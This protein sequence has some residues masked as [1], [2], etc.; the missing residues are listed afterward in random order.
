MARCSPSLQW[1]AELPELWA[2]RLILGHVN[3]PPYPASFGKMIPTRSTT[4]ESARVRRCYQFPLLAHRRSPTGLPN[5][6]T[7]WKASALHWI[8][9][10]VPL[11]RGLV[12]V[13]LEP[14]SANA[15]ILNQ[16][17]GLPKTKSLRNFTIASRVASV[18]I[19]WWFIRSTT[20]ST[21]SS[22]AVFRSSPSTPSYD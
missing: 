14:S 13:G 1:L 9:F 21:P 20:L 2:C 10:D 7:T 15:L 11:A 3:P 16:F 22:W 19:S 6:M 5:F 8:L 18:T 17:R 12:W 4:W